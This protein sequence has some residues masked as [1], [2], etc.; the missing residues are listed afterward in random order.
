MCL[1]IP[2]KIISVSGEKFLVENASSEDKDQQEVRSI[3]EVKKGDIVF[4]QGGVIIEKIDQKQL[5]EINNILKTYK[6][7]E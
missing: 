6:K 3:I 2:K 1:T 5:D 7:N 4:T